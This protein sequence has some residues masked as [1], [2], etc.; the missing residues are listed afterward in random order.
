MGYSRIDMRPSRRLC[1]LLGVSVLVGSLPA[2]ARTAATSPPAADDSDAKQLLRARKYPEAAAAFEQ[3]F[4]ATS[5]PEHLFDAA[6]A[7]ELAGHEGHAAALWRRYLAQPGLQPAE[8][9]RAEDRLA[10]L[11][12]RTAAVQIVTLPH[13]LLARGLELTIEP[14]PAG[15]DG[16]PPPLVLAGD[17]LPSFAA[18]DLPGVFTVPLERGTW[19]LS[20]RADG[21]EPARH[22]FT[23]AGGRVQVEL[24]LPAAAPV[25]APVNLR[26]TPIEAITSGAELVLT[27]EGDTP[28]H[29]RLGSTAKIWQ[30]AAGDYELDI[31]APGYTPIHHRFTVAG[32]PLILEFTL[33]PEPPEPAPAASLRPDAWTIGLAAGGGLTTVLGVIL[34]GVGGARW[35]AT[36]DRYRQYAG[37]DR[38]NWNAASVNLFMAWKTYGA[39]AGLLGGGIGLGLGAVGMHFAPRLTRPRAMWAVGA[40]V[41]GVLA[42][43]GG[44]L[45]GRR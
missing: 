39:G 13:D 37:A 14:G 45:I 1:A 40:A 22:E 7:R 44:L 19:V 34:L 33:V 42:I 5:A 10:A 29:E 35:S 26:V 27:R 38:R 3:L 36:L 8:V 31:R 25:V 9:E 2:H 11:E 12:R 32:E 23:V 41:G 6:V 28:A 15:R 20:A 43:T 17:L 18:P 30:L 16:Q 4:A 24:T 21:H